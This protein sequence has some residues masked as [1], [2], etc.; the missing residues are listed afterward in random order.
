MH[1]TVNG[2]THQVDAP[3]TISDLVEHLALTQQ[4][5]AIEVN[6]QIIPRSRFTE[7]QLQPEDK[8]EIVHAI[9]GG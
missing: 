4:R 2:A 9:G 1:I 8:V 7:H 6:Q 5:I 3:C